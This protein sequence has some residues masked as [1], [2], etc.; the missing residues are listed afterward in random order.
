M[1]TLEETTLSKVSEIINPVRR[2]TVDDWMKVAFPAIRGNILDDGTK[3]IRVFK[4]LS[5]FEEFTDDKLEKE[6]FVCDV[7]KPVN[8]HLWVHSLAH[9]GFIY[10]PNEEEYK[11]CKAYQAAQDQLIFEGFE[12][13]GNIKVVNKGITI[14]FGGSIINIR[15]GGIDEFLHV[16]PKTP[17]ILDF[18]IEIDRYNRTASEPIKINL[19]K[20]FIKKLIA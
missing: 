4:L 17:T 5:R 12:N 6:H 16:I 15:F 14:S 20:S 10:N 18:I 7:E 13:S 11:K 9:D 8:Y 19:H 2:L 1:T 3:M